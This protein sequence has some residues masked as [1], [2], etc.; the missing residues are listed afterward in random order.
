ALRMDLKALKASPA[1]Q[2]ADIDKSLAK[3]ERV[4]ACLGRINAVLEDFATRAVETADAFCALATPL[5]TLETKTHDRESTTSPG[6]D[7]NGALSRLDDEL[8]SFM[9]ASG[10][11]W[12]VNR[13]QKPCISAVDSA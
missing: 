8:R 13:L 10:I 1:P 9:S 11:E 3:L 4:Q 5:A 6:G 2:A 7:I 12:R